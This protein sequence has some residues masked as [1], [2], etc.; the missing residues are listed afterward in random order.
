MGPFLTVV[1]AVPEN[2]Q[3][4]VLASKANAWMAWS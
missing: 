3:A 4:S 2:K 1:P